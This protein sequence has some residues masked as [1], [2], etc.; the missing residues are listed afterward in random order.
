MLTVLPDDFLGVLGQSP[1][2]TSY[3]AGLIIFITGCFLTLNIAKDVKTAKIALCFLLTFSAGI[4]FLLLHLAP[5]EMIDLSGLG[6][7]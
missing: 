3:T 6:I 2:L 4:A 7:N 5:V 1:Y